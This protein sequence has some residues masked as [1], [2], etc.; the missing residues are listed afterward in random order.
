[1]GA[2]KFARVPASVPS[3]PEAVLVGGRTVDI[4]VRA[5]VVAVIPTPRFGRENEVAATVAAA[6]S[7]GADL[8]DIS[9]GPRLLGPMARGGPIPA[10]ARVADLAA[11][12]AAHA[13][14]A[15]LVLV[16]PALGPAAVERDW[17]AAVVVDDVADIA[18]AREV[19]APLGL[20]LAVDTAGAAEAD[21]LAVESVALAEGC[22]IVRTTD[23]RRTRR[24]VEVVAAILEARR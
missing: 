9:H 20:P 13:A 4:R 2:G 21:A 1:V 19:A 5:L 7:A 17:P 8:A 11:G 23:V 14:G 16:P 18:A 24:V 6:A 12:A 22:R 10:C 15:A 3:F